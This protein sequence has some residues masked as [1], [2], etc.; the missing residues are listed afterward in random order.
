LVP[1]KCSIAPSV[2]AL[3]AAGFLSTACG[4][5]SPPASEAPKAEGAATA[6]PSDSGA[7]APAAE[8]DASKKKIPDACAGDG[9]SCTMPKAFVKRLCGGSYPDLAL[10]LFAKS[11]PWRRAYVSVKEADAFNGYGGP[12][13]DEKLVFE[14]ELLVLAEKKVDT[15]GMQVSGAGASYDCLRWDGTCATLS[16]E[17]V[18]FAAPSKPKHATV[19]WRALADDTQNALLQNDA[20]SKTATERRKECKGAT[21][22]SVTAKCEKLDHKLND[23]V[24]EAVRSGASVPQPSKLP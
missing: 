12:S 7:P 13:S 4:G 23:V 19:P 5:S 15:G 21:T 24:V 18:R 20:V 3:V 8:D 14:E 11:T 10:L 6:A 9:S 17:E 16:A 1:S 2:A 22:G